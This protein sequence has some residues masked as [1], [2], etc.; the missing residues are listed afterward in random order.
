[1]ECLLRGERQSRGEINLQL[2]AST[3]MWTEDVPT[4]RSKHRIPSEDCVCASH[5]A[6]CLL[7]FGVG[8]APCCE[9]DDGCRHHD[10]RCCD[11]AE[12]GVV[13]ERLRVDEGGRT[14]WKGERM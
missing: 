4:W 13:W 3:W 12:D 14:L 11:R 9:T 10:A 6:E 7:C 8:L 2:E 5:E 1:M